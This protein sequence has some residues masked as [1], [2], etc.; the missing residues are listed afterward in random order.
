MEQK[1]KV[2]NITLMDEIET[3]EAEELYEIHHRKY[4]S[5]IAI[6]VLLLILFTALTISFGIKT[7][8]DKTSLIIF[9]VLSGISMLAVIAG[10]SNYINKIKPYKKLLQIAKL[11]DRIRHEEKIRFKERKRL[12]LNPEENYSSKDVDKTIEQ[13]KN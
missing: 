8:I 6:P 2:K 13:T 4:S 7:T 9:C 1:I 10:I 5:F 3:K 11:N 12:E